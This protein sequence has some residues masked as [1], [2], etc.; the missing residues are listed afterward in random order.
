MCIAGTRAEISTEP[1]SEDR[2]QFQNNLFMLAKSLLHELVHVFVTF[3][4]GGLSDT[5][6]HVTVNTHGVP[7][8]TIGE[9]GRYINIYV[10]GGL[11]T[12]MKD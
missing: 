2:R 4:R 7:E 6:P 3:L 1:D 9:A 12:V 5:S 11:T 10:L 8:L